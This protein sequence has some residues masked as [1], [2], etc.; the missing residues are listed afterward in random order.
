VDI[1]LD[2]ER[3]DEVRERGGLYVIGTGRYPAARTD[4]QLRGRAGRRGEPGESQFYLSVGDN[5]VL[6]HN[7]DAA[8][9]LVASPGLPDNAPLAAKA[10]TRVVDTAQLRAEEGPAARRISE[11]VW[12]AVLGQQRKVIYRRRREILE[13][14]DLVAVVRSL[15]ANTITAYIADAHAQGW[16]LDELRLELKRIYPVGTTSAE[17]ADSGAGLAHDGMVAGLITDAERAYCTREA[18]IE[19]TVGPGA[20]RRV[21][22]AALLSIIDGHW[23]EYLRQLGD[24]RRTADWRAQANP[25]GMATKSVDHYG[26]ESHA[27]FSAMSSA[28]DRESLRC[29]FN[30]EVVPAG[31]PSMTE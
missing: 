19:A 21:E 22:R 1:P 27:M 16:D 7:H 17:L 12:D 4:L 29:L 11:P 3:G 15:I 30:V 18:E 23:R 8:E 25:P 31:P 24:L 5:L 13:Q 26:R 9:S 28:L 6:R 14:R 2:T 10:V 20:M